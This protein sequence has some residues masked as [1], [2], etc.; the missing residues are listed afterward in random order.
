MVSRLVLM[1][2]TSLI[3]EVNSLLAISIVTVRLLNYLSEKLFKTVDLPSPPATS[4]PGR[5]FA[6]FAS[7]RTKDGPSLRDFSRSSSSL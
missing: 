3:Y 5:S 6:L 1:D 7:R 4:A 2:P